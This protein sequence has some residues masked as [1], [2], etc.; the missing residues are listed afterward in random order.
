MDYKKSLRVWNVRTDL[1]LVEE[2]GFVKSTFDP[3]L[4]YSIIDS[5]YIMFL[6]Y[7]DDLILE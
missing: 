7:V 6:L 5:K 4:Y 2:L 1:F 3:N